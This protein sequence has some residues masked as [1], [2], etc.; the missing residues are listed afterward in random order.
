MSS[1][2]NIH[3]GRTETTNSTHKV[4]VTVFDFSGILVE[5]VKPPEHTPVISNKKRYEEA[6]S[7]SVSAIASFA[8]RPQDESEA[9]ESSETSQISLPLRKASLNNNVSEGN[10]NSKFKLSPLSSVRKSRRKH[11]VDNIEEYEA[12]WY[13]NNQEVSKVSLDAD[14]K[15]CEREIY[16]VMVHLVKAA[17]EPIPIGVAK[18]VVKNSDLEDNESIAFMV[19]LNIRV[20]FRKLTSSNQDMPSSESFEQAP[21]Q[22]SLSTDR[23]GRRETV[24]SFNRP[25]GYAYGITD[26]AILRLRLDIDKNVQEINQETI[27]I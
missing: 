7:S 26:D 1:L 25:N 10:S 17:D 13:G 20:L 21:S 16:D 3:H 6:T 4:N 15:S 14:F 22:N 27:I 23:N 24:L 18:L 12:V 11:Y 5:K 2:A 8:R 9:Y 19:N